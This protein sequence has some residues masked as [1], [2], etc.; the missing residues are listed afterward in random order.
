RCLDASVYTDTRPPALATARIVESYRT[1][2]TP[3][4]VFGDPTELESPRLVTTAARWSP[5]QGGDA[6]NDAYGRAYPITDPGSAAW[7]SFSSATLGFAPAPID[8]VRWQAF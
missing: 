1:R 2:R 7:R 5:T 3:G 6:L 4:V 8:P